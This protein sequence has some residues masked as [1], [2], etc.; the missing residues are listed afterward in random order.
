M[1]IA[2]YTR[3]LPRGQGT[4]RRARGGCAVRH[5]WISLFQGGSGSHGGAMLSR[6]RLIRTRSEGR[7]ARLR[8]LHE[9]SERV[10]RFERKLWLMART[11]CPDPSGRELLLGATGKA[12]LSDGIVDVLRSGALRGAMS[13]PTTFALRREHTASL[14]P[15]APYHR[16]CFAAVRS[17]PREQ[18]W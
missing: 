1:G 16:P 8:A 9:E 12:V 11:R 7:L 17:K 14:C 13:R 2:G 4:L 15:G 6:L 3:S 10:R 18:A 5:R